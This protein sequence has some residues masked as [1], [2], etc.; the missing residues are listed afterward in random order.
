MKLTALRRTAAEIAAAA[1]FETY[2]QVELLGGGETSSGFLYE[3]IF[4]HPVNPETLPQIEERMRQIA[5][6][7]RPIRTL[8]M[9]PFSAKELLKREGHQAQAEAL[10]EEGLVD[11]IQIGT[12][13]DLSEGPH[14]K[15]S[16]ELAFFKLLSLEPFGDK[17][18]RL[19]GAVHHSK[20]ELKDLLRKIAAYGE[21][22]HL[23]VGEKRG[24]W[25]VL[26]E[27][28]IWKEKG[29]K[30]RSQLVEIL[31]KR[32]FPGA[33]EISG[34]LDAER[35]DL[36]RR[37]AQGLKN[38]PE[39]IAEVLTHQTAESS[40][41]GAGLFNG[42]DETQILISS[43]SPHPVFEEALISSLQTIDQTLNI[44]GFNRS[45]HLRSRK[46]GE[47]SF[48]RLAKAVEKLGWKAEID[49]QEGQ[50]TQIDFEI[51]DEMGR[52]W[53]VAQLRVF[54]AKELQKEGSFLTLSVEK[55]LA[56]LLEKNLEARLNELE[57]LGCKELNQMVQ[58]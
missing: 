28:I 57:K 38:P 39:R 21:K 7:A 51:E 20:Q 49:L 23:I 13:H 37:M 1:V 53:P 42:F 32:F 45:L 8:E 6:E 40:E 4:P 22:N 2:P 25:A 46:A 29:L 33:L 58:H 19:S 31:K 24:L 56:L 9:V 36:Y 55:I 35:P 10:P 3:F 47:Q 54:H 11:I 5:R 14:L 50:A 30:L 48:L 52:I 12:F 43:Y 16:N 34:P 41:E 18:L 26:D 15:N 27:E 44:L 17:G